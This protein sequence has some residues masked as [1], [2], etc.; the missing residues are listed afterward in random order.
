MLV[1]VLRGHIPPM[2]PHSNWAHAPSISLNTPADWSMHWLSSLCL[3]SPLTTHYVEY[4]WHSAPLILSVVFPNTST[5]L[6]RWMRHTPTDVT[7]ASPDLSSQS[8]ILPLAVICSS[9]AILTPQRWE[10]RISPM[11]PHYDPQ[12]V[13]LKKDY[14][15]KEQGTPEV[16]SPNCT[17][18]ISQNNCA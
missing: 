8:T 10:A 4:W 7:E 5:E 9:Y 11:I 6:C 18:Q 3:P 14:Q 1:L 12:N 13:L 17:N 2:T 15:L 16:T